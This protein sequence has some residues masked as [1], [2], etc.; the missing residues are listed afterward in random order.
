MKIS[1]IKNETSYLSA[2]AMSERSREKSAYKRTDLKLNKDQINTTIKEKSDGRVSFK[3]EAP[4]LYKASEF[5]LNNQLLAEAIFAL[6]ITCGMRPAVIMTT[7]KT[8]EDKEK[9]HY[10]AA[11]SISSGLVGLA[12]T[13]LVSNPLKTV[14]NK[15]ENDGLLNLPNSVKEKNQYAIETGLNALNNA[16]DNLTTKIDLGKLTEGNKFNFGVFEKKGEASLRHFKNSLGK[17][18]PIY[19]DYIKKGIN[20]Q[21]SNNGYA[22]AA[23]SVMD[24]LIQPVFMPVR[25]MITIA[26][27]PVILKALGLKKGGKPK[28]EQQA[29]QPQLQTNIYNTLN[30]GIKPE[31]EIFK[32]FMEV[33]NNENK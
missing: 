5:V 21:K 7:A 15:V 23:R 13:L 20:A 6:L 10:Q 17:E 16:K 24:K 29:Q 25:A 2:K 22:K 4:A 33:S 18:A 27:V 11:K 19:K 26:L 12:T 28:P 32:S 3:G 30:T 31:K 8:E 14:I 9:C 1:S